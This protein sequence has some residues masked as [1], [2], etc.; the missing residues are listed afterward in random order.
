MFIAI[1]PMGAWRRAPR[2]DSHDA[3]ILITLLPQ[4]GSFLKR[5]LNW[6]QENSVSHASIRENH[7]S[8]GVHSTSID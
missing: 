8:I 1:V 3:D 5:Q 4:K 7:S 2:L 6:Q